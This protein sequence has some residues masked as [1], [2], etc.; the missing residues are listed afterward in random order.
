MP[1]TPLIHVGYHKTATTWAQ[2][3]LFVEKYGYRQIADHDDVDRLITRPSSF[4]FDADAART[5][6]TQAMEAA[7]AG[8]VPVISSEILSGHPFRGGHESALYAQ[9]LKAIFPEA[10]ILCSIRNQLAILPSVYMQYLLRGGT[11]DH[12]RFFAGESTVGYFGFDP[13]HFLYHHLV[14]LYREI[15]GPR[16]VLVMTQ[17]SL[18][19]DMQAAADRLARFAGVSEPALLD[20][21]TRRVHAASY[22]E[23]AAPLL[24]RV[25]QFQTSLLNPAPVLRLGRT[26][27]GMY[28]AA[29]F[30]S[31]RG[32]FPRL[33]AGRKPVTTHVRAAFAGRFAESNRAL[34]AMCP[35]LDLSA[36]ET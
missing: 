19:K 28:R 17:E 10:R 29:G 36:Y 23:Y 1:R 32:P 9:R 12:V 3:L 31:K 30:V 34:Q 5:H 25:N 16:N 26:P 7:P 6:F 20:T 4:G 22:P 33:L 11:M 14:G 2:Q 35:D 15:F 27:D 8:L 21:E 24:R 13:D 18:R